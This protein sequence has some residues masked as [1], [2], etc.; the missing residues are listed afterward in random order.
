[1]HSGK[2]FKGIVEHF[3]QK[4]CVCLIVMAIEKFSGLIFKPVSKTGT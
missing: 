1:M 4:H 3:H 2:N